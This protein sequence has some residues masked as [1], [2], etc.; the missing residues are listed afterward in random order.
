MVPVEIGRLEETGRLNA[1]KRQSVEL[2]GVALERLGVSR[3]L[4][5]DR[6]GHHR[7]LHDVR[8]RELVVA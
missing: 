1:R 3:V 6:E 8:V 2:T 4:E 7:V 5:G